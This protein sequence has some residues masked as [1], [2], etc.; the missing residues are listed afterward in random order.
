MVILL[1]SGTHADINAVVR[2]CIINPKEGHLPHRFWKFDLR[3]TY[4]YTKTKTSNR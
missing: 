2:N 3:K 4:N 1:E